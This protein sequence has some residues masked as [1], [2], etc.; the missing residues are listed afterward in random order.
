MDS[1]T[2]FDYAAVGSP[3]LIAIQAIGGGILLTGGNWVQEH[4][5]KKISFLN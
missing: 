1:K 2:R 5:A 3:P 4:V